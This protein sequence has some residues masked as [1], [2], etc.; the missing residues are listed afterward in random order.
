M[1]RFIFQLKI[2][3]LTQRYIFRSRPILT[4][5]NTSENQNVLVRAAFYDKKAG[6][7]RAL[8]YGFLCDSYC[9]LLQSSP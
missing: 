7:N 8:M 4:C 3:L 2:C 9:S 6:L 5:A 1:W